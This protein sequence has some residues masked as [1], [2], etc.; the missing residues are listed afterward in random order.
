MK[1]LIALLMALMCLCSL[2]ACSAKEATFTIQDLSLSVPASFIPLHGDPAF[3]D[4]DFLFSDGKVTVAGIREDK[5]LLPE[6]TLETFGQLVI[7]A[8]ELDCQLLE[9]DGITFFNYEAGDPAFTYTVSVWETENAFWSV[10]T[11]CK[12][13]DYAAVREDMWQLLRSVKL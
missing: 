2:S 8:H 4:Y 5:A 9:S 7:H 12:S 6:L 1:R 10:Q 11:Y 13:E 3:A